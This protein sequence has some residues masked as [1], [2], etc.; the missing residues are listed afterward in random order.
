MNQQ[1]SAY[2]PEQAHFEANQ[3]LA[4]RSTLRGDLFI[5]LILGFVALAA[6]FLYLVYYG[7]NLPVTIAVILVVYFSIAVVTSSPARF[8]IRMTIDDRGIDFRSR[9]RTWDRSV[10]WDQ[11]VRIVAADSPPGHF[12]KVHFYMLSIYRH[13]RISNT[14]RVYLGEVGFTEFEKAAAER[15]IPVMFY[16]PRK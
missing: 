10:G 5:V 15:G 1:D 2:D 4:A 6:G 14:L 11:V 12:Y 9:F 8:P 13:R 3:R 7:S 16:P